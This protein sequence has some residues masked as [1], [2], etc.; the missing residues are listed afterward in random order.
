MVNSLKDRGSRNEVLRTSLSQPA[1]IP[2]SIVSSRVRVEFRS[3]FK[4]FS[5][6]GCL[7]VAFM[8]VLYTILGGGSRVWGGFIFN[9]RKCLSIKDLGFGPP[10]LPDLGNPR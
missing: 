3:K 9:R 2:C 5:I 10:G 8:R 1:Q 4:N 6:S 7:L